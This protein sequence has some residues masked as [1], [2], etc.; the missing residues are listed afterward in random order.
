MAEIPVELVL[1]LRDEASKQAGEVADRLGGVKTATLAIGG[2]VVVGIGALAAGLYSCAK[3]AG[4]EEAGIA[5]LGAAVRAT[6]ADWGE[7]SAAIEQYLAAQTRR[8]GL[9]DGA[10]REALISLTTTTHDYKRAMD[11]LPLALDLAAAKNMDL[12]SAAQLVGRVAEGNV[13]ILSRYGIVL[14]EGATATEALAKMQETFGGQ[15]EAYA[16]TY[17]GAMQRLNVELGNIK[18]AIGAAV[19][20]ALTSFISTLADLAGD[21]IPKVEGAINA[22]WPVVQSAFDQVKAFVSGAW[23]IVQPILQTFASWFSGEGTTATGGWRDTVDGVFNAVK[24]VIDNVMKFVEPL[25]HDTIDRITTWWNENY[26]LI[27]QTCETVLGGIQTFIE[28]T[29]GVIKGFWDAHGDD[30][31]RIMKNA[32]EAVKT[33]VD[34][35]LGAIGGIITAAMLLINGDWEGAWNA[36]KGVVETLWN[37]IKEDIRLAIDIIKT[38]LFDIALPEIK[39]LWDTAWGEIKAKADEIWEAIK[40][41]VRT[42]IDEVKTSITTKIDE[43]KT[44]IGQQPGAFLNL[45]QALID[46]LKQGVT[47]AA[48]ALV[49]AVRGAINNAINAAKNLLGIH[50]PSEVFAEFGAGMMAGLKGGVEENAASAINAVIKAFQDINTK[51]LEGAKTV[52][53]AVADLAKN[54][55]AIVA[56]FKAIGGYAGITEAFGMDVWIPGL[57]RL[58]EDIPQ[59]VAAFK[60]LH[61]LLKGQLSE[62]LVKFSKALEDLVTPWVGITKALTE[63][64]KYTGIT[65]A[66]G[67]DL[68]IP[69]LAALETDIPLVVQSLKRI[70]ESVKGLVTTEL[71]AGFKGIVELAQQIG[72]LC[73][74]IAQAVTA[75]LAILTME[76]PEEKGALMQFRDAVMLMVEFVRLQLVTLEMYLGEF[77]KWLRAFTL[78]DEGAGIIQ[79]LIDAIKAG[80]DECYAAGYEAGRLV[81]QGIMDGL[82]SMQEAVRR[83]AWE[84]AGIAAQGVAQSLQIESPSKV[85]EALGVQAGLGFWQGMQTTAAPVTNQSFTLNYTAVRPAAG[86]SDAVTQMKML[87]LMARV[88]HG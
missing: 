53:A 55:E 72:P 42:K 1:K 52:A 75:G 51:G 49:E 15:A 71:V 76:R 35:V 9:D 84:L 25:I 32:F 26:G 41:A 7:A 82:N 29:L 54:M 64:K 37:G 10:G 57:A 83:A 38:I 21:A 27:K 40:T 48:G 88:R 85:M 68:W 31:E 22:F 62:E 69:A 50:S 80:W 19:L 2:A 77:K 39:R 67:I 59:V 3:A 43:I 4:E 61:E 78:H 34:T 73:D 33:V 79:S 86:Y 16:G 60:R 66:F 13:G 87:E 24:T 70:Y 47:N 20:P 65:E 14:G 46:G 58:E 28:T 30:I 6:G 36:I 23:A 45:G 44:W 81:G 18:E 56:G 17:Q 74:A 5:R 63:L 8:V 11:L 12:N